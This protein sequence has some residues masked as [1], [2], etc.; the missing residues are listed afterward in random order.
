MSEQRANLK[1]GAKMDG[2]F[3]SA[4]AA[5]DVGEAD[6]CPSSCLPEPRD[7]QSAEP[8]RP[9]GVLSRQTDARTGLGGADDQTG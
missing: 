3:L 2:L 8:R 4:E 5:R 6:E 9:R 7:K 1:Q